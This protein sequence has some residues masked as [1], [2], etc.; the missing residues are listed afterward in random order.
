MGSR[1][2]TSARTMAC[3]R[4]A[5]RS[6]MAASSAGPSAR[7]A[8]AVMKIPATRTLLNVVIVPPWADAGAAP[9][10][11]AVRHGAPYCPRAVKHAASPPRR[12]HAQRVPGDRHE[13]VGH[14]HERERGE[15]EAGGRRD[16]QPEHEPGAA[17]DVDLVKHV[18]QHGRHAAGLAAGRDV[19][20]PLAE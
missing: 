18:E 19:E 11:R 6:L 5:S 17:D 8:A 15:N 4:R 10:R 14:E 20:L 2:L 9:E 12:A 13:L 3:T 16:H 7:A 1:A